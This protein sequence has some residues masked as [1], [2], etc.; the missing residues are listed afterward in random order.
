MDIVFALGTFSRADG[1][2]FA[3]LVL[4][5][6][7][8]DLRMAL[9][10]E[11]TTGALF[12]DWDSAV[13]QLAALAADPLGPG[14]PLD[15]LRALPPVYPPGQVLCAGANYTE[16]V[17]EMAFAHFSTAADGRSA[18]ELREAADA[19]VT[20]LERTDP[21]LF[22]GL[23]SAQCGAADD[24]VL[25][26]PGHEHDWELELAVVIGRG[27][28]DISETEAME[29]VAGY[30]IVNDVTT[31]DLVHRPGFPLSDTVMSKCRPTFF[32]TGPYIVP[33]VFVD[34][35]ERLRITLRVNGELM[36]DGGVDEMLHPIARLVAYAS[37]AAELRPGDLILTGSPSGNAAQH[38]GR[39]LR[40]GDI[41]EG[42]ITG[43]GRQTNRCIAP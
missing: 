13:T 28:R 40:P 2:P 15:D 41:V 22:G 43:L 16:H 14:V 9:G 18:S 31:R 37:T 34:D 30:T 27:G 39:W 24:I 17:R 11:I 5:G 4:G 20:R 42:E 32:P 23:A 12:A 38:G 36:Q 8:Y 19:A 26:G 6:Q 10:S 33:R 21:F 7:V 29:H 3:G 35:P 25:R 1:E